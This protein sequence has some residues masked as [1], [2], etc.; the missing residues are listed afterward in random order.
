MDV[1]TIQKRRR[2]RTANNEFWEWETE[3]QASPKYRLHLIDLL[4]I[5]NSHDGRYDIGKLNN[6]KLFPLN[7]PFSWFLTYT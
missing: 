4:L 5:S 7:T 3:Y 2:N 6:E 1:H